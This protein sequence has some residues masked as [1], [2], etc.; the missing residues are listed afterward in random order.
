MNKR[1]KELQEKLE[2]KKLD[3]F[4]ITNPINRNYL[5]GFTGSTGYL[6][7]AKEKGYFITDSRYMEQAKLEVPGY[8]VIITSNYFK[9][10]C[11]IIINKKI[12]RLG[13]EYNS[14]LFSQYEFLKERLEKIKWRGIKNF[15]EDLR[16]IKTDEEIDLIKKAVKIAELSYEKTQGR[17]KE[18]ISEKDIACEL[19]YNMKKL[20]ADGVSFSTIVA[21]G[22]RGAL[23][24]GISSDKK[25]K[26]GEL[27]IIDFGV[28]YKGY[29]S[30]LTKTIGLGIIQKSYKEAYRVV[31]NAQQ[32]AI[33][34]IK[35]G[36][37]LSNL[38]KAARNY[39][40][41]HKLHK[42][43]IHSLGHGIGKEVHEGPKVSHKSTGFVK[44]GMVFTVEPGIYISGKF[45]IRIE[46]IIVV[47]KDSIEVLGKDQSKLV[48]L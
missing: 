23:P 33:S 29:C 19:E 8:E 25:L 45:G 6:L 1:I 46:N 32:E 31:Y 24:H 13:Y 16:M 7:I 39:L 20:G 10:I 43:F 42:Y 12:K 41:K 36:V 34:F 35:S 28:S 3:G 4:I 15:I 21:S 5:T 2:K 26:K 9:K 27:I 18:G 14:I 22:N 11:E 30:D 47:K 17:I 40:K 48:V 38:D 44:E 37:K